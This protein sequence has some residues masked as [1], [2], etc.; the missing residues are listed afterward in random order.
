MYKVLVMDKFCFDIIAPL[1][2]VD[3]LRRHGVTLHLKLENE[4]QPIADVPAVYFVQPTRANV[5]RIASDFKNGLYEAYHLNF[6]SSL[7]RQLLEELAT[8]S[9]KA[10]AAS[11][12]AKVFDQYVNFVSLSGDAFSLAQKDAY[13]ALNDPTATDAEVETAVADIVQGLFSV[14]VTLGQ[15]PII[16]CPKGGAAEM[17]AS[18]LER[19]LR[20]HMKGKGSLFSELGGGAGS[21]GAQRTLLCL[22]DRNFDLTAP[23]QHVWTYQPLVHDVLNMRLNRV[24]VKGES[25]ADA[26]APNAGK[27]SYD[28]E[29]ND[30]FWTSNAAAQFPKVAEEVEAELARY[31]KAVEALN[32]Q[33]DL[34]ATDEDM[35]DNTKKLVSAVQSLPELQVR[36]PTTAAGK[37]TRCVLFFFQ[38][39]VR[40]PAR[41]SLPSYLIFFRRVTRDVS[42]RAGA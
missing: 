15:L 16:R 10:E 27:K 29:D 42:L 7:P 32:A 30:P 22:F 20:D 26:A 28:L 19:T 9:V 13:V 24:D 21:A 2:R 34:G 4:R 38:P 40:V 37:V 11:K 8:E 41:Q 17:I 33:T 14:C 18:E 35:A 1:V 23:L 6:S 25:A 36:K 31:K 39:R 12:V 5:G 3:E